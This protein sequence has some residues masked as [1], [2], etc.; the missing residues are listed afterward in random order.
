MNIVWF[1]NDLRIEDNKALY[2]AS[3]SGEKILPIF[4]IDENVMKLGSASKVWLYHSLCHLDNLLDNKLMILVGD[5]IN[6]MSDLV[7]KYAINKIYYNKVYE[8]NYLLLDKKIEDHVDSIYKITCYNY[9]SSLLFDPDSIKNKSGGNYNVF[10]PFYKCCFENRD[11]IEKLFDNH[12]I[13]YVDNV[14]IKKEINILIKLANTKWARN[15]VKHW[16]IGATNAINKFNNFLMNNIANYKVGRDIPSIN[17]ISKLSPHIHFGEIS[18]N[19]IWH[20]IKNRIYEENIEHFFRELC[21]REFAYNILFYNIKLP[22]KNINKKFDKFPW[23]K[24]TDYYIKWQKGL[25][26]IPIVDAG[27]RELWQTGY[28]HNR[29]R[30]IVGSFLV[31]NLLIHWQ[32]GARWFNNCLFDA[33]LANNSASWQ[34]VSGCGVDAAPYFRIF[35]PILQSEKFDPNGIYIKKYVPELNNLPIKYLFNPWLTPKTVLEDCNIKLGIDYPYPI[36]DLANSRD[37]ALQIY[38]SL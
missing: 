5:S 26:G 27:M 8:P 19:Y 16:D 12:K 17:S 29:V 25:T 36:V 14:D 3:Q 10:T 38:K 4:I 21:W 15:I 13:N 6:V 11:K 35:N 34:W 22:F 23:N 2:Y 28:M 9:N 30:M 20:S 1:R 24:N 33:D 32:D 37:N 7:E 18:V 31:K